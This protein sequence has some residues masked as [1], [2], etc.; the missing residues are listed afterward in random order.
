MTTGQDMLLV[1]FAGCHLEPFGRITV[2]WTR[3]HFS[4][5]RI[6][7]WNNSA[8]SSPA[9]VGARLCLEW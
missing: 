3:A 7:Y 6:G 2:D 5:E 1:S 9:A 4:C 8:Y